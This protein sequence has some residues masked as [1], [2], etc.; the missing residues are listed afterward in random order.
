MILRNI[1]EKFAWVSWQA[2]SSENDWVFTGQLS[3]SESCLHHPLIGVVSAYFAIILSNTRHIHPLD[4]TACNTKN[5][6]TGGIR[7]LQSH[8]QDGE[9]DGYGANMRGCIWLHGNWTSGALG[10][11]KTLLAV[12]LLLLC[13][14]LFPPV[15]IYSSPSG[16]NGI[17]RGVTFFSFGFLCLYLNFDPIS[18]LSISLLFRE[19]SLSA[20]LRFGR[21]D[22][23][24]RVDWINLGNL[25][26]HSIVSFLDF[27]CWSPFWKLTAGCRDPHTLLW[28]SLVVD[29][30]SLHS[31]NMSN[32]CISF[33][34]VLML[35]R[36]FGIWRLVVEIL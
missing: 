12:T 2:K 4:A 21:G 11:H 25:W 31:D 36:L 8:S 35:G 29:W 9:S 33:F 22:I 1:H 5:A 28:S 7:G 32:R 27:K 15:L 13:C 26:V 14:D 23:F 34:A 10:N 16:G 20:A 30:V 18:G 24:S 19:H 17:Y 6:M 3:G